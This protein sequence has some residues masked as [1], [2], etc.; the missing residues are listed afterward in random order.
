[1]AVP[2][3]AAAMTPGAAAA[4]APTTAGTM[5]VTRRVVGGGIA[6]TGEEPLVII[7]MNAEGACWHA[8]GVDSGGAEGWGAHRVEQEPPPGL[9]SPQALAAASPCSEPNSRTCPNAIAWA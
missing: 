2:G 9:L 5:S 7:K 1:M 6:A 3:P 8:C 4:A